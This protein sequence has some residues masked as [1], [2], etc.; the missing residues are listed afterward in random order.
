MGF[1]DIEMNLVARLDSSSVK[2]IK[3]EVQTYKSFSYGK[4]DIYFVFLSSDVEK[5]VL[6]LKQQVLF[7]FSLSQY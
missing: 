6:L 4:G 2:K 5:M 3:F 1:S 7:I